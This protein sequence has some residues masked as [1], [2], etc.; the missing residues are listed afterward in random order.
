M[1]TTIGLLILFSFAGLPSGHG[2]TPNRPEP[3]ESSIAY[4]CIATKVINIATFVC[5][6]VHVYE[7]EVNESHSTR[8]KKV[9]FWHHF[10]DL[11][12]TTDSLKNTASYGP[13][14]D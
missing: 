11:D 6:S 4:V 5:V 1:A 12:V 3:S 14:C 2:Q 7:Q 8:G 10:M 9:I 13:S